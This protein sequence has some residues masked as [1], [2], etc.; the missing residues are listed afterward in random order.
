MMASMA[1]DDEEEET[2]D[3]DIAEMITQTFNTIGSNDLAA[4][5]AYL[6]S[7]ESGMEAYTNAIEYGYSVTPTV[8]LW[9]GE[10]YRQVNPDL[11]F[12]PLG[13]SS[14]SS[15]NS[16]M[17]SMT[18]TDVFTPCRKMPAF[19]SIN[20]MSKPGAGPKIRTNACWC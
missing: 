17:S 6:D 7:G 11:S 12:A 13:I 3:I 16:M 15:A 19:I 2:Y 5:K 10:D 4:L 9:N 20:M 1:A 14:T 18:S 8:Y